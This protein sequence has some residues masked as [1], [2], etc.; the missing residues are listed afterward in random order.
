MAAPDTAAAATPGTNPARSHAEQYILKYGK[1]QWRRARKT[2]HCRHWWTQQC[3]GT[4]EIVA[5]EN[6][7][8]TQELDGSAGGFGTHRACAVCANNP[9]EAA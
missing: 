7:F 2:H 3:L 4:G 9:A 8:D 1:G 5:G 6:Y